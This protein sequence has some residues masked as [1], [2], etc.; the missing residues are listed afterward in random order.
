[1]G[2]SRVNHETG[3]EHVIYSFGPDPD[4]SYPNAAPLADV[5]GNLYGTTETGGT[6]GQGVLYRLSPAGSETILHN[7]SGTSDGA[8]PTG[9]LVRD[10]SGNLYGVTVIGG[11]HNF[12]V[13]FRYSPNGL[14]AVLHN[15]GDSS[16]DGIEPL[17]G[18]VIDAEGNLYGTTQLGGT[19]GYGTVFELTTAGSLQI[20]H[21]FTWGSDGGAP[22]GGVIRD[23]DGNLYGT[24]RGGGDP[25]CHCGVVFKITP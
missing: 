18:L 10:A 23:H 5:A 19:A 13:I 22:W 25:L 4:G 15:F 21:S 8:Q 6:I 12:G 20:L 9:R 24:T 14:F 3:L 1:M 17:D 16:P 2:F 7:F 11:A